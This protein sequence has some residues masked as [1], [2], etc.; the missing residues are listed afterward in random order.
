MRLSFRCHK[1]REIERAVLAL[2][3]VC[4]SLQIV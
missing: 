1:L 3:T 4:K 2:L